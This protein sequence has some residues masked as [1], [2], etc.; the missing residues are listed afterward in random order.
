MV[1]YLNSNLLTLLNIHAPYKAARIT[2]IYAPWLSRGIRDLIDLRNKVLANFKKVDNRNI[3]TVT[4][5][6]E[7]WS[8]RQ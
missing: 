4:N 2:K 5:N 3:G 1:A 8:T 6:L 7:T